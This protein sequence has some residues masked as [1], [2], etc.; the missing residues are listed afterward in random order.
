MVSHQ[1][2]IHVIMKQVVAKHVAMEDV[3][4]KDVI[5]VSMAYS[6]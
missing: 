2:K 5:K 1:T 6:L 3:I 4:M